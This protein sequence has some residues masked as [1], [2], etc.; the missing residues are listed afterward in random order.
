M[1][2][3]LSTVSHGTFENHTWDFLGLIIPAAF[4]ITV[5]IVTS[6]GWG[7]VPDAYLHKY[8]PKLQ[9]LSIDYKFQFFQHVLR[10]SCEWRRMHTIACTEIVGLNEDIFREQ[11]LQPLVSC[12]RQYRK[13]ER[14][15]EKIEE[16][17]SVRLLIVCGEMR[18]NGTRFR[19]MC[20][21]R[22]MVKIA[23]ALCTI[24]EYLR[25]EAVKVNA[26]IDGW[27]DLVTQN[28]R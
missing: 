23:R 5:I 9:R 25:M 6:V 17:V 22:E 1:C 28:E 27:N 26:D 12:W 13:K 19:C 24:L 2:S 8:F 11:I 15:R 4:I 16:T 10:H 18:F 14:G 20:E 7:F 21:S 3:V